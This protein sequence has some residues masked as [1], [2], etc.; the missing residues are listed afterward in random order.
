MAVNS[1]VVNGETILDLRNATATAEQILEGVTA[2]GASGELLVGTAKTTKRVEV[3]VSLPADGWA[4]FEQTSQ[5]S[6]MTAEATVFAGADLSCAS[7]YTECGVYCSAQSSENLT[8]SCST[9]PSEG[10]IANVVFFI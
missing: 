4:N 9:V 2:Y 6:G 3:N 5:I 8:F 7:E 1:V 10:L